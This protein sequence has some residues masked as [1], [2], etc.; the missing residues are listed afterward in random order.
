MIP[1]FISVHAVVVL[2]LVV[3][4]LFWLPF[5][6]LWVNLLY[7]AS[8]YFRSGTFKTSYLDLP[9]G[10]FMYLRQKMWAQVR[11]SS[12]KLQKKKNYA[13]KAL[14]NELRLLGWI[15]RVK[16]YIP[17]NQNIDLILWHTQLIVCAE[18]VKSCF[19]S[20]GFPS[21]F[22]TS[23]IL[24]HTLNCMSVSLFKFHIWILEQF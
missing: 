5:T 3:S 20:W 10:Y 7:F 9:K 8:M 16:L 15:L 13:V 21:P 23:Y 18:N 12:Q 24:P 1:K 2:V 14:C 22:Q 4:A 6:M 19:K 11:N 17:S